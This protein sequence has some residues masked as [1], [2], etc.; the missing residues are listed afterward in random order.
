MK[1]GAKTGYTDSR[2]D[3]SSIFLSMLED[4]IKRALMANE[5]FS[6]VFAKLETYE[7]LRYAIGDSGLATA[8]LILRDAFNTVVGPSG[9]FCSAD[10]QGISAIVLPAMRPV[11]AAVTAERIRRVALA[12]S[13]LVE[14]TGYLVKQVA[15]CFG[16]GEYQGQSARDFTT[17]VQNALYKSMISSAY[18]VALESPKHQ[19]MFLSKLRAIEREP[20]SVSTYVRK[21]I[22]EVVN[23]FGQDS[24]VVA[25]QMRSMSSADQ[26]QFDETEL[27]MSVKRIV[28][29]VYGYDCEIVP[30][31][32]G[33]A[34]V[35]CT[36]DREPDE[37]E[38]NELCAELSKAVRARVQTITGRKVE[39]NVQ[40][41]DN[42]VRTRPDNF[43]EHDDFIEKNLAD[44]MRFILDS[45]ENLDPNTV[46]LSP[47]LSSKR[48]ATANV[49]VG[50]SSRYRER[51]DIPRDPS[52]YFSA[53]PFSLLVDIACLRRAVKLARTH[54]AGGIFQQC[55]V[56]FNAFNLLDEN[57]RPLIEIEMR[58]IPRLVRRMIDVSIVRTG[59]GTPLEKI[60]EQ[61]VFLKQFARRVYV[62]TSTSA[63][64]P[65]DIFETGADGVGIFVDASRKDV[66]GREEQLARIKLITSANKER[67]PIILMG[68]PKRA[69][70]VYLDAVTP[71]FFTVKPEQTRLPSLAMEF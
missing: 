33:I 59:P 58:N 41:L 12:R 45:L 4:Q 60:T 50:Y 37:M 26:V 49:L 13:A 61:V 29:P 3:Y 42:L 5:P 21:R 53:D 2:Q 40:V 25:V 9:W 24:L 28:A 14:D 64:L 68:L 46:E 23:F 69:T 54:L 44:R 1:A 19:K 55:T 35:Y 20:V 22:D 31:R 71:E 7:D 56:H 16:V 52:S 11:E 67:L 8:D 38:Q 51:M 57:Y 47:G 39:A 36:V 10:D 63:E 43:I 62:T 17:D 6:L 48:R 30:A 32:N 70:D 34:I 18:K 15:F 66:P 65:F 27:A